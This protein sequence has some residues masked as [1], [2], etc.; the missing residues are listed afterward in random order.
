MRA[1][2]RGNLSRADYATIL[3]DLSRFW[4]QA[5]PKSRDLPDAYHQFLADY[6]AALRADSTAVPGDATLRLRFDE[7]AFF[8]LLLGSSHGARYM[9]QFPVDNSLPRQHLRLLA[10]NGKELWNRFRQEAL[11][12]L[13]GARE[14]RVMASARQMFDCLHHSIDTTTD[15]T[16]G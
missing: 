1:Y 7:I 9:L 8:Y 5:E 12:N 16:T 14:R 6:R 11:M 3:A 2:A 15:T 10:R 4:Q 13:D